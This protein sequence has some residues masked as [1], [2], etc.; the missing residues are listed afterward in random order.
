MNYQ[1]RSTKN[2]SDPVKTSSDELFSLMNVIRSAGL[3]VE[4]NKI[5]DLA[6]DLFKRLAVFFYKK[7]MPCL[8]IAFIGGTGTGKSTLFNALC[9]KHLSKTGVER[10]KTGGPIVYAHATCP[11]IEDFPFPNIKLEKQD[12]NDHFTSPSSGLPDHLLIFTHNRK[13]RPHLVLLDTPDMDSVETANQKIVEDFYLLSDAVV[14]VTSQE[15]YADDIPYQFLQKI[16]KDEKPCFLLVNK[17]YE[18]LTREEILEPLQ[19]QGASFPKDKI[20]LIPYSS[21]NPE[22]S[23]IKDPGFLSFVSNFKTRFSSQQAE[24]FHSDQQSK[25]T[26]ELTTRIERLVGLLKKENIETQNWL[27]QLEDLFNESCQDLIEAEKRRFATESRQYLQREIRKLF[28]R[29]DPLAKPRRIIRQ[30]LSAPF[31]LLGLAL[32]NTNST[33]KNELSKV[34][35]KI[36]LTPIQGAIGR[37]NR[38]VL[39]RLSP[40]NENSPLLRKLRQPKV[41]LSDEEI[42]AFVLKEHDLLDS[43]L[44]KRF[45]DL[46]QG[47]PRHKRWGIYSTS[48]LWGILILSFEIVVGGGFSGLD[49]I[50]DSVLA[51]FVTKGSME[52]FAYREIQQVAKELGN[53]YQ[54]ALLNVVYRQKHRYEKVLQDFVTSPQTLVKLKQ[55]QEDIKLEGQT[56]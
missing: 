35:Q 14:F 30:I 38:L 50:L 45:E 25:R 56:I 26:G 20:W 13:D 34:R 31:R 8:W 42:K 48:V 27:N 49:A 17:A 6:E 23:I 53:R 10:P 54:E 46:S 43:W 19:S 41:I 36:D 52:L 33:H 7:R 9:G 21:S 12:L 47:L 15:K 16:V 29:Y 32:G 5:K 3:T 4:A 2:N 22:Q 55:L 51:P 18:H 39:E 44:E 28:T 1:G 37:F 40:K 24:S 11:I